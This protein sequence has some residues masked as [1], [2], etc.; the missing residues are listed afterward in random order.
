MH[1]EN[2][3]FNDLNESLNKHSKFYKKS[4]EDE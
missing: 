2:N 3:N 1:K 4:H